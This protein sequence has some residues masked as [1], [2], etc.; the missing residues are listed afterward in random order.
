M[1]VG[2]DG[3]MREM[4]T[5]RIVLLNGASSSGKTCIARQLLMLL[6]P[7]HFH[8]AVDAFGAMRASQKTRDLAPGDLAEV[9][10]KT[11]AGFHRAVA[12]M[13]FA[14]NNI[15]MDHVLSEPWRLDDCLVVLAPYDVT[16]V[17]VHC[18]LA[19]LECREKRRSDRSIGIAA[20]QYELVHAHEDYDVEVDTEA[21]S[22]ARCAQQIQG[23]LKH[24]PATK[25]FDRLRRGRS[26]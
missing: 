6:D 23:A 7:P 19:E 25:A 4:S 16:L 17:A 13:A 14:G 21:S 20:A 5:G 1:A 8:M 26:T 15:V 9:L 11:R 12:G 18:S 3:D 10:Q 2:H 22:P 24:L